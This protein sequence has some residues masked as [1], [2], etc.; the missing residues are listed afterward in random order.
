[1]FL[2]KNQYDI[3]CVTEHWLKEY[4]MLINYENYCVGSSFNRKS[5]TH[6]GSLILV[7]RNIKYKTRKDIEGLSIE[8]NVEVSCVELD[9]HIIVCVYR[10]PNNQNFV[11]FE[12]VLE[13]IL[14]LISNLKKHII[15]CGDFNVNILESS[16]YTNRLICLFKSFN[17]QNV[18]L[19][20]TR[21]TS[22]SATC[23]DNVFCNCEYSSKSIIN[24][25][26]SDHS[27]QEVTFPAL[28][29]TSK[30]II[31]TRPITSGR[32]EK[33]NN[34]LNEKLP[35]YDYDLRNPNNF[36][37]EFF[38]IVFKEFE[39]IFQMKKKN[40]NIKFKFSDW[41]TVGIRKSREKLFELYDLKN[42]INSDRFNEY[43]KKYSKTFKKICVTAKA[44]H[45]SNKIKNAD[46]KIKA[47]WNIINSETCKNK[48]RENDFILKSDKG[49]VS[50]NE[51]VAQEF[52]NFFTNIPVITT[53][54]L[55][56]SS[57]LAS[58]LLN[59]HVKACVTEFQFRHVSLQTVIKAF[60][61]IKIK[62][63]ED[64][65]G[66]SVK[67]CSSVISTLAPYLACIFNECVDEGIF[68][69][70]MKHSK[71]IPLFKAGD[72]ED[73]SNFRPVSVLP[74]LSKV[75]EK[76]ILNQMLSHF[77]VNDLLHKQQF[78]FT[79][80]RSTTDAGVAL[81]KHIFDAWEAS[82]DAV[83]VFCDLSK[84]FDCVDHETLLLKLEHYGVRNKS[85]KLL[86]S[87]L[88]NRV[89]KVYINGTKS[90][91]SQ[92]KMGVPQGSIL[93]PFLF[94]VYINDLPHVVEN[95]SN[96]VLFADDTSLIFKVDRKIQNN[97]HVNNTL[98][99]THDWFTSN[100]LVLNA[101]KTKCIKFSLPNVKSC[102]SQ[103]LL[104]NEKL[105]LID[106]TVFLGMTLDS[107]LQWGPHI[108]SLS[109]R[110]SSAAYAVRK[111]RQLTDIATARLVYFSYFHSIMS[112]G[113][114]LWGRAADIDS[115]F[116]L[117]KRAV[118][119]IYQLRSRDSLRER[120]KEINIMTVPCQYIYENI[121]YARKNLQNFS[122]NC[123]RH[124]HN[125]RNK[126]KL[127][128]PQCR[129]AKVR[130]SFVGLC[131]RYYNKIPDDVLN[132]PEKKFKCFIKQTLCKKAY[133]KLEEYL[134]D[135]EAWHSDTPARHKKHA[136]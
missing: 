100:N 7:R 49:P 94:L 134:S 121:M 119:A 32:L 54:P 102:D 26:Q 30:A 21:V 63:T 108:F 103:L 10:P 57:S 62:N 117:Q 123:D 83:G 41:A 64:L 22:S 113:I 28:I 86:Q 11:N 17:L 88:E 70:L 96:I 79:K 89:Q 76:I 29:S 136:Y 58:A 16:I 59:K 1:M 129:L 132:L 2:E 6:G 114:L 128:E 69:D 9:K 101:R 92:V 85:L 115:I 8:R 87:Y 125:T 73:P 44:V 67:I 97:D 37:T 126:N 66:M 12:T 122:K 133:Y 116:V 47:V 3:V 50:S 35:V 111:I 107:K 112:Y 127:F 36:Y 52:E 71:V 40:V 90:L 68:P 48:Q 118:R 53:A 78:G 55:N 84:A 65:W 98:K 75:F 14:K 82:C 46:N 4:Q 15:V 74:V 91:G 25:L 110:L 105:D 131:V 124:N 80:G 34:I 61:E 93:G 13:D 31:Q 104:N 60:R 95:L 72:K 43:V 51:E 24:S 77:N 45:I 130:T 99:Q 33:Y 18:F 135:K 120:F 106:S 81:V 5:T 42:Y 27:G 39:N 23:I 38:L 20:P 56:S 19:E 109:G